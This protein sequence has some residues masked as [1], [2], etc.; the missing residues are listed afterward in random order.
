MFGGCEAVLRA[1]VHGDHFGPCWPIFDH[2]L[3]TDDVFEK[4]GIHD[5]I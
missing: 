2:N 1:T 3:G 5:L 4:F